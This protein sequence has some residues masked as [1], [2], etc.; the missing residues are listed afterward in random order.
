[1]SE[2]GIIGHCLV[3][4]LPEIVISAGV[5]FFKSDGG[6]KQTRIDNKALKNRTM[7]SKK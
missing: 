6:R 2:R 5:W 4:V 7:L 1:M 3:V